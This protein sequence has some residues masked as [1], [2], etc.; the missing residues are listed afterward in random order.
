MAVP[1][2]RETGAPS[3]DVGEFSFDG[4]EASALL[5][6]GLTGSPYEMRYL[7]ERIA[8]SGFRARGV[9]LAGHGGSPE[10]LART[11][12][13]DWYKS[14]EQGFDE[15]RSH[16]DPV[17]A[18]GLSMGAVLAARL[19]CERS[20][21]VAGV[22]MLASAFYLNRSAEFALAIAR[23]FGPFARRFHLAGNGPDIADPETRRVYPRVTLMPVAAALELTQLSAHV[24]EKLDNIR[25]PAIIVHSRQDHVCPYR[26]NVS[27]LMRQLA[28]PDKRLVTLEE[29]FHVVTVDRE[30]ERVAG[31]VVAFLKKCRFPKRA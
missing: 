17:V 21:E 27:L 31:E 7:G 24:R 1:A 25:G 20:D 4:R 26:R 14:A 13:E 5:I 6:H 16:G 10:A 18:V 9:C 19:A 11:S 29:S 22:A 12:F 28:V 15:L 3:L 8:Q 23:Y 2:S 30:R